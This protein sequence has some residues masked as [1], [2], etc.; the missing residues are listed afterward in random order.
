MSV[1][2]AVLLLVAALACRAAAA[3]VDERL[4]DQIEDIRLVDDQIHPQVGGNAPDTEWHPLYPFP[5]L[6]EA[7]HQPLPARLRPGTPDLVRA[8]RGLFGYRHD[9][10][11]PAHVREGIDA[12]RLTQATQGEAYPSWVLDRLG[13]DVALANR[14]RLAP[15]IDV[16]RFRW[17]AFA[18]ALLF[19]LGTG[20][21]AAENPERKVYFDAIRRERA[22]LG[23]RPPATLPDYLEEVIT[24]TLVRMQQEG[25]VAI[26]LEGVG[27]QRP[28]AMGVDEFEARAVYARHAFG[29]EPP[30]REYEELRSFL[31]RYVAQEASRLGLVVHIHTGTD[32]GAGFGLRGVRPSDLGWLVDDAV[33]GWTNFV[34]V[35]GGWPSTAEVAAML[36]K[37]NIFADIS[38]QSYGLSPPLLAAS[39]RPWLELYPEKVLFGTGA[40]P[41]TNELGWE[42]TAWLGVTNARTALAMALGGMVEDGVVT[43]ARALEI[44][45]MV[46]RD[47]AVALY[48]LSPS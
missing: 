4:L 18:D 39:L 47:N 29:A 36:A 19:P 6:V 30:P 21:Q 7:L 32:L 34:L 14:T 43:R 12:K 17:V 11:E 28:A 8:W 31:V 23:G 16:P 46:L 2:A 45:R 37:P 20:P 27:L 3:E 41:L 25:A 15:G 42:E 38:A 26:K 10:L 40:L 35:Q 22:A 5:S 24:P 33:V 48:K 1:R 9:D 13:V 44:A